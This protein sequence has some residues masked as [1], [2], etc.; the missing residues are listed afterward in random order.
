MDPIAT[1]ARAA[2]AVSDGDHAAALQLSSAAVAGAPAPLFLALL[3][4]ERAQAQLGAGLLDDARTSIQA[5]LE[6]S[7]AGNYLTHVATGHALDARLQRLM[8]QLVEAEHSAHQALAM[9]A[10]LPAKATVVDALEVLAGV[11]ADLESYQ[12]AARL[13][14]AAAAIR[15]RTGYRRCVS[16]RD[17]DLAAL[18][19]VLGPETFE[20]AY[21][22][23]QRLSLDDAVAYAQRGRGERKRPSTGWASLSPAELQ[24]VHLVKDG[25]TNADIARRLFISPRTAQTHLSHIFAKLGIAS[26]TE[27]AT[28]AVKR[29]L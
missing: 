7:R 3:L 28:A 1:K 5:L 4:P 10:A 13:L 8:R 25:L 11:A 17:A 6:V 27:L 22:E 16:E 2:I 14:G 21:Q 18:R 20:Q 12:E 15:D 29:G 9:A 19:E 26:R 23:G 24:V